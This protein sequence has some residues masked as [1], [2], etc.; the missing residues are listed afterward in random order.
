MTIQFPFLLSRFS[1]TPLRKHMPGDMRCVLVALALLA[2]VG[3]AGESRPAVI[4]QPPM[5]RPPLPRSVGPIFLGMTTHEFARVT[6]VVPEECGSDCNFMQASAQVWVDTL[7]RPAKTRGG[8]DS[9]GL[10]WMSVLSFFVKD[11][12]YII[13]IFDLR[14]VASSVQ[15][16]IAGRYGPP[17]TTDSS[18]RIWSRIIW[19]QGPTTVILSYE[20]APS[21]Y[22]SLPVGILLSSAYA[23]NRLGFIHDSVSKDW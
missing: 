18:D 6:G 1:G 21:P 5:I 17:D 23:D 12:L 19:A 16:Q 11:S 2:C 22:D 20:H 8:K 15:A 13:N 14:S 10:E 9:P 7:T 3:Q 4:R